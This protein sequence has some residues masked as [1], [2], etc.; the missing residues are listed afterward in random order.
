MLAEI[1][2]RRAKASA[3][4]SNYSETDRARR[5]VEAP[6]E[7]SAGICEYTRLPVSQQALRRSSLH[8]TRERYVDHAAWYL[9]IAAV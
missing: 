4:R 2:V 1:A 8:A 7:V 9:P 5:A 3:D 6:R